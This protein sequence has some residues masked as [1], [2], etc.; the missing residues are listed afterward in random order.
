MEVLRSRQELIAWR[1]SRPFFADLAFVPTMG[2]LHQG[3]LNLVESALQ[4]SG[5]TL[6]SIFV[7]PS[8]FDDPKD[9]EAYPRD[10]DADLERLS[11]HHVDAVYLPDVKDIYPADQPTI[12]LH[13]GPMGDVLCGPFRRGHFE[14]VLTVVSIFFHQVWPRVAVFGAKDFQQAKLIERMIRDYALPIELIQV[15]TAREPGGL[16]LSSRNQRLS[17]AG[18]RVATLIPKAL[19]AAKDAI[20]HGTPLDQALLALTQALTSVDGLSLQY[21]EIHD[22]QTLGPVLSQTKDVVIGVAAFVDDVRLIDNAV[23]A[24]SL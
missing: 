6:V 11:K 5:E 14:G 24:F 9:F 15:P 23:V 19:F 7:N 2:S 21:A 10:V 4:A 20:G 18:R 17:P 12:S 13:P 16:A 3:H 8:Q 22:A 1:R